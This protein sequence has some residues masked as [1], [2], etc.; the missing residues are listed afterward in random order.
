MENKKICPHCKTENP[1]V[2]IFCKRC[3]ALFRGEPQIKEVY[4]G[5]QNKK[6]LIIFIVCVVLLVLAFIIFKAGS[7]DKNTVVTTQSTLSSTAT[8][9]VAPPSTSA[10]TTETTAQSTTASTTALTLPT[11]PSTTKATT[12]PTTAKPMTQE[13]IQEICDEFNELVYNLKNSDYNLSVHKTD[14]VK[15]EIT[16]FSLPFPMKTVN[17]FMANLI[18]KTDE[19]YNFSN[20]VASES[21]S[22]NLSSYIPPA[23]A[24]GSSISA[25]NVK[26]AKKDANG[27]ITI[28]FKADSS[29]FSDG[30]TVIPPHVSTATDYLDFANFALG[31]VKITKAEIKYPKTAVRIMVDDEGDITKLLIRQPVVISCTGGVNTLT[32]DVGLNIVPLT[33]Y[34]ITYK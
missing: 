5:S 12:A 26:S 20:G 33:T 8:T 30:Q 9:T 7:A 11:L 19:T 13:E 24:D 28:V 31:N 2:A 14:E 17:L 25:E 32:A 4:E 6:N 23:S 22:I 34:E 15:L 27:T 3:G 10:T 18:P 16:S 1:E 21:A 29:T